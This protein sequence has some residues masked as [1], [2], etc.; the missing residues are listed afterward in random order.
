[1]AAFGFFYLRSVRSRHAAESLA[2]ENTRLLQQSQRE[3]LTDALTGLPNRRALA[4]DLDQQF[5]DPRRRATLCMFDLDGFKVYNDTFGHAAGDALLARLGA[6]LAAA[7]EGSGTAYRM[8]GDE[9]CVLITSAPALLRSEASSLAAAAA[10]AE[11]GDGWNVSASAGVVDLTREARDADEA[12]QYADARMY[13]DK[14]ARK[15]GER[16]FARE[17]ANGDLARRATEVEQL[18]ARTASELGLPDEEI[19]TVRAAARMYNVGL[20]ALP[21]SILDKPGPLDPDEWAFVHRHP[22]V[23]ERML[24]AEALAAAANLVRSSHE[25]ADGC[26]YPDGLRG[27]EIPLGARIIAVCGAYAAMTS[28]RP[29]ASAMSA[30]DA[31]AEL[32]RQSGKQ[33]DKSVVEAFARS[34]SA[35]EQDRDRVSATGVALQTRR[36]V[37]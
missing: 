26:G 17:P 1:M 28:Q 36:P 35:L 30:D 4:R 27:E 11:S 29:Y 25:R 20:R 10:L 22:L 34:L 18:A 12:L 9:F 13:T 16:R 19:G 23:A 8:G 5:A 14:A 3:A 21:S 6:K 33:F 7:V 31:R 37:Y 15:G 2:A 32:A 24:A